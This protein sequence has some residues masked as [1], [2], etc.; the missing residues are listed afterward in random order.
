MTMRLKI[1]LPFQVFADVAAVTR[2]VVETTQGAYGLLP[3]RRDAVMVLRPGLL[4]YETE[5][6]TGSEVVVA[7]DGG[8][9]VKTGAQV[10]VSVRR[11]MGGT[12]LDGLRAAV[13]HE[14]MQQSAEELRVHE[15]L[16][17]LEVGLLR[18]LGEVQDG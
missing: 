8:V 15:V 18:R 10:L 5:A 12:D 11:A 16:A 2:L 14:F 1:L 6:E 13:Q 4:I 9:L 3:R 7:V 17:K